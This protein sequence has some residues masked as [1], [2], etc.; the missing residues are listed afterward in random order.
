MTSRSLEVKNSYHPNKTP[1]KWWRR[2][3]SSS[4]K[5]VARGSSSCP[6]ATP[7][8]NQECLCGLPKRQEAAH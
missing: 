3:S 6:R 4:T 8:Q 2:L 1:G 5:R 7:T